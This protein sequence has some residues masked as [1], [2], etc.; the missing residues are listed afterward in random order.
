MELP[1]P[2]LQLLNKSEIT[3]I[4]G[5]YSNDGTL[6]LVPLTIVK[7]PSRDVILLLQSVEPGIQDALVQV[8]EQ[9]LRVSIL[10]IEHLKGEMK[11]YQITCAVL[12][13]QT[14]GPLFEKFVDELRVTYRGLQGVWI[15]KPLS[16]KERC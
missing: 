15:L 16:V 10:C 1:Q 5:V 3:K 2:I 13:Y 14:A 4:L 7:V 11:A 12:E 6:H 8:M 9:D